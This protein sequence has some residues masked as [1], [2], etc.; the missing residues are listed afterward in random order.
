M[1]RFVVFKLVDLAK[2]IEKAAR[3]YKEAVKNKKPEKLSERFIFI[4]NIPFVV[5]EDTYAKYFKVQVEILNPE[6]IE[7]TLKSLNLSSYEEKPRPRIYC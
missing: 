7:E 2:E 5:S 4:R 1:N 6:L 3:L